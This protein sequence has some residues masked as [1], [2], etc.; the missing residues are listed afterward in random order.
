MRKKLLVALILLVGSFNSI[1][2]LSENFSDGDFTN[3]P[4][5]VGDA[6]DWIVNPAFQLQSNNTVVN[7]TYYLSTDN[8]KA[9]TA[10]WDFFVQISFN[11][12]SANY[13]DV[14]LTA[15]ASD[16]TQAATTGYFVRIGGTDDEISLF[17]KDNGTSVKIIDGVNASLNSSLSAIQVKVIRDG[18]NQW[19]LQR[20]INGG[21]STSEGF[22]V[23]ANYLSSSFFGV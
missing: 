3:N 22:V 11:P 1:A 7:S 15:S 13:V 19:L 14:F 20:V 2:Q 21:P 8:T 9:T 16:L 18:S 6:A 12:S 4:A 17:R 23:D 5:W 10:K